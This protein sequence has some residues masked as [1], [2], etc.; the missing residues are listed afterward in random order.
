[1]KSAEYQYII[2][3]E[4]KINSIQSETFKTMESYGVNISQF[5]RSAI[6]EKLK[7]DWSTIK[8]EHENMFKIKAPW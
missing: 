8:T 4:I 6:D 1:M 2:R 5:I 7:R 3:K